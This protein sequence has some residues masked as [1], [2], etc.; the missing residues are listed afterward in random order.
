MSLA[1]RG[2]SF[3][4]AMGEPVP[5]P[6]ERAECPTARGPAAHR[7]ND[8]RRPAQHASAA[9]AHIELR[10]MPEKLAHSDFRCCPEERMQ[11]DP[12]LLAELKCLVMK[13]TLGG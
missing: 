5:I 7:C 3:A 9:V 11:C 12:Q 6:L 4:L 1:I 2:A 13:S 10:P 8:S